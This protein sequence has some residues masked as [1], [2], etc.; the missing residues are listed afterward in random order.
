MTR[1]EAL[2]QAIVWDDGTRLA[3]GWGGGKMYMTY[4][5]KDGEERTCLYQSG[6]GACLEAPLDLAGVDWIPERVLAGG[7]DGRRVIRSMAGKYFCGAAAGIT[8]VPADQ[9]TPRL[10]NDANPETPLP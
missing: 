6:A 9:T 10:G 4:R 3:F 1:R 5:R 8:Q 7:L 2:D